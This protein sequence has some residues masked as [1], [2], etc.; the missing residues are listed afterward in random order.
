MGYDGRPIG[1]DLTIVTVVLQY[2]LFP[3]HQLDFSLFARVNSVEITQGTLFVHTH[4]V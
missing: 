4:R 2:G 3:T 1:P